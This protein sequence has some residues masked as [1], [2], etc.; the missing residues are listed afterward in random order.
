MKFD[1]DSLIEKFK[2]GNIRALAKILT[3]VENN[4]EYSKNIFEKLKIENT[5]HIIGFTGSP[6]AGKSSLIDSLITKIR[7]NN[8][9]VG[10]IAID[11]SS[12]F[13][14]GAIL[15]DRIRMIKHSTDKKVFIRSMANRGQSGGLAL[16]TLKACKILS[17]FGFDIVIVE[18]VGTGQT[19]VEIIKTA[20]TIVLVLNPES[21]DDIQAIKAGIME[22]ADIFVINKSDLP[23]ANRTKINIETLVH[24]SNKSGWKT[25]VIMTSTFK[26]E[27][28]E[29]LFLKINEHKNYLFK[30]NE[31]E[32]RKYIQS[33]NEIILLLEN[34][35]RKYLENKL[36]DEEIS[37]I[38]KDA[39]LNKK[40]T[41]DAVDEIFKKL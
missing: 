9:S 26:N 6:G 4:Y 37:N 1:L 25:P 2:Q 16:S 18:T 10:I 35:I 8:L 14:G 22:I 36:K 41:Y 15:G 24:E 19:E 13:T 29:E 12:P 17:A 30:S 11:P 38:I 7:E 34:K 21:G 31:I 23:G 3:L 39:V 20:D 28:I 32:K 33:E 27:G 5:S 40:T